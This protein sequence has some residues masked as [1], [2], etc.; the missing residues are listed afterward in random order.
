MFNVNIDVSALQNLANYDAVQK[1]AENAASQLALLTQAKINEFSNERLKTRKEKFLEGISLQQEESGVWLIHIDESVHWINDGVEEHSMLPDFL[2]SDKTKIAADGHRYMV[3]PFEF[4]AGKGGPTQNT[5]YQQDLVDAI[6]KQL[7]EAKVPWAKIEKN[8]QGEA[9]LGRLHSLSFNTP[10]K[11][12]SGPGMGW[13]KVG[14]PRMGATNIPFLQ[15]AAV[16]Q[17]KNEKGKIDRSVMT[18]RVASE[19]HLGTGRWFHPGLESTHIMEDAYAWAL[20][21]VDTNIMPSVIKQ[22]ERESR[23][24]RVKRLTDF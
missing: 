20:K 4:R 11:T 6:K 1:I 18:F 14:D 17:T 15:G 24:E 19:K 3:I 5:P 8:D 21:E 10:V 9:K 2:N 12:K 16:Y 23:I 22:I 7:K 13:G